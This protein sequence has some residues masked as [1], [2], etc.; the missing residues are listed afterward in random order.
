MF[1]P[2]NC[3][4]HISFMRQTKKKMSWSN[5]SSTNKTIQL[6]YNL[7]LFGS[8]C[9][10]WSFRLIFRS[11]LFSVFYSFGS[12][13][14]KLYVPLTFPD[15]NEKKH[16]P[17]ARVEQGRPRVRHSSRIQ[18]RYRLAGTGHEHQAHKYTHFLSPRLF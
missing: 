18:D 14:L 12:K 13:R 4:N 9:L 1:I 11:E 8:F 5:Y 17:T 10:C 16:T 7:L 2:K 3:Y 15:P 6:I